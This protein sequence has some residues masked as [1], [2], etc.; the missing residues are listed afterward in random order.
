MAATVGELSHHYL[1]SNFGEADRGKQRR[2]EKG[3]GRDMVGGKEGEGGI[4]CSTRD[5]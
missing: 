2:R 3:R 5:T 4:L 1:F